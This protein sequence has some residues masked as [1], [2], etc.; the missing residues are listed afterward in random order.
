MRYH[1]HADTSEKAQE[2][3]SFGQGHPAMAHCGAALPNKFG[4]LFVLAPRD[5]NLQ[6]RIVL[7]A[8]CVLVSGAVLKLCTVAF[9]VPFT[10]VLSPKT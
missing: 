4:C 6:R 3:R 8:G 5:H 7:I 10:K 2:T 9:L 1:R